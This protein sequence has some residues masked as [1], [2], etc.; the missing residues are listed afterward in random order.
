[1]PYIN[2]FVHSLLFGKTFE[3]GLYKNRHL[4]TELIITNGIGNNDI[5]DLRLFCKPEIVNL[6]IHSI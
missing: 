4:N 3:Y 6:K 1:M 2:S 5:F